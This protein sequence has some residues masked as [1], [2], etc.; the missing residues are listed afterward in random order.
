M[1]APGRVTTT[2]NSSPPTRASRWPLDALPEAAGDLL[3]QAVAGVMAEGVVDL[4]EAVEIEIDHRDGRAL[5]APCASVAL[6]SAATSAARLGRPLNS[7][8]VAA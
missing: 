4:L 1:T 8:W 7:S 5:V 6:S 2:A 3:Q